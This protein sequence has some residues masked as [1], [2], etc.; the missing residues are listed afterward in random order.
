MQPR[1]LP[2]SA[3]AVAKLLD[4]IWPSVMQANA[5]AVGAG[6]IA[7]ELIMFADPK[8]PLPVTAKDTVRRPLAVELYKD[9]VD[10]LYAAQESEDDTSAHAMATAR[11]PRA[12]VNP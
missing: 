12:L 5:Q 6:R 10:A 9:E 11:E 7:K 8:K 4:T 3:I 2:K 1:T